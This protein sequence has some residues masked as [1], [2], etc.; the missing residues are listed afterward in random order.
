M[1]SKSQKLLI[2]YKNN[3]KKQQI[4]TYKEVETKLLQLFQRLEQQTGVLSLL[5]EACN[6]NKTAPGGTRGKQQVIKRQR[7]FP[8][9]QQNN[10]GD[11]LKLTEPALYTQHGNIACVYLLVCEWLGSINI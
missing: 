11:P 6:K 7:S 3:K 10:T 4:F 8:V 2:Y 1:K 5:T 9:V